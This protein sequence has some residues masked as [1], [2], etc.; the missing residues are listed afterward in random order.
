MHEHRVNAQV[1]RLNLISTSSV[2]TTVHIRGYK[3]QWDILQG[4][5]EHLT[6]FHRPRV[7]I[8][9]LSNAPPPKMKLLNAAAAAVVV[10]LT[11]VGALAR[12]NFA[13][14][15]V[16]NS[17]NTGSYTCRTQAQWD[18]I[19]S[20]A[21]NN[22]LG[23]IRLVGFDCNALNMASSAAA[24]N[25]I[26]VMAGI[27]ANGGTIANSITQINNDVQ[28]FRTAYATY[29]AGLYLGL[30]IGN[31]VGDTADNIMAAVYN[32]RDYLRSV[33]VST[34]V[35][36]VHTWVQIRALRALCG[37]DF[38]GANAHVFYDGS[39]TSAQ[40]G[41]FVF[42]TVVPALREACPGKKIYITESGWPS[43][44]GN[45][46]SAA[47]ASVADGRSALLNLNCACRNDP[48]ISVFAFEYDDQAWKGNDN[49]KSF[50][51]IGKYDLNGDVFA[52]C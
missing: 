48:S 13:G 11:S 4:E 34:P 51:V 47:V 19:A 25:G 27:Y 6:S 23:A 45:F 46:G 17:Q 43:R 5:K 33:G 30:N 52:S 29:G 7:A 44:G 18:Q 21:R 14:I 36:T 20:D 37:G 15:T 50:G 12:T 28:T 3:G 10:L 26:K 2:P 49:E 42:G 39:H 1:A 32:I 31:E 38:V 41:D 24:T 35:S 16:S 8:L 40:A 9:S 22:G